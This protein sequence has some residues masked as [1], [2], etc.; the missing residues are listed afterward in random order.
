MEDSAGR[1]VVAGKAG[2]ALSRRELLLTAS[3]ALFAGGCGG[4]GGG[5]ADAA[6]TALGSSGARSRMA[7]IADSQAERWT[8]AATVFPAEV[9]VVTSRP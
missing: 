6:V 8:R 7:A 2:P 3:A 9:N 4:D 5:Q 1:S